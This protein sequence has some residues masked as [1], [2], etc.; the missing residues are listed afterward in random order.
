[1]ASA[2]E[3]LNF[4]FYIILINLNSHMWIVAT[5]IS[6]ALGFFVFVFLVVFDILGK[7]FFIFKREEKFTH[8]FP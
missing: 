6:V 2:T 1:M 8:N 4:L 5:V 7:T 3:E